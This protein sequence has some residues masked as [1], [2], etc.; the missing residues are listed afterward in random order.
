MAIG[1]IFSA[2]VERIVAG[3]AGFARKDGR[4]VFIG[5]SSPG[6]KV[7]ARIVRE[8]RGWV[9]A[10]PLEILEASPLRVRPD[11]PLYG[12]CG[13]CSLQHLAYESQLEAKKSILW[14]SFT[15]T[16]VLSTVPEPAVF[17]S[18]PWE[19]RNRMQFHRLPNARGV[20]LMARKSDRAVPLSDCPAA[21]RG[22]RE[23]LASGTLSPP[24]DKDRFTIYSRETLLL[25]EGGLS[26][27]KV[28]IRGE[29]LWLDAAVFFQSNA[30]MLERLTG[31]LLAL[32]GEADTS[33]PLADIYCGVGTFAF[34]LKGL[35]PRIDLVEENRAALALARENVQGEGN[36]YFAMKDEQWA[37]GRRQ[38]GYGLIVADPPRQG[39]SPAMRTWL[40]GSDAPLLAY[41]SCDSA[42]LARD[43]RELL[44]G[45]WNLEELWLYDFYPHTPHIE[46][47]AV[48]KKEW[49][50]D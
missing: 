29:E 10:E 20:G 45:G 34:F 38:S 41:V 7:C 24:P 36:G 17:P 12:I 30:S 5:L 15:H 22:I 49:N 1:E 31:D 16:G 39:L 25:R 32:A 48:F 19:Y 27:G 42:T 40:A 44:A 47:L 6:D 18:S 35:F 33:R 9:E 28:K 4:P 23:L 8:S 3:G 14:E 2:T 37:R 11:C 43:S 46:S 13:G 26:R 21:D 50:H